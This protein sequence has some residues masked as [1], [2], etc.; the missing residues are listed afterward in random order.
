MV[1][2]CGFRPLA[3]SRTALRS[4]DC[5]LLYEMAGEGFCDENKFCMVEQ[6]LFDSLDPFVF[7]TGR[8]I[9][10]SA[11]VVAGTML[12]ASFSRAVCRKE[13]N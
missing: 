2:V 6:R 8:Y 13:R 10:A 3:S 12:F 5:H 7:K 11:D 4:A 9:A 1:D